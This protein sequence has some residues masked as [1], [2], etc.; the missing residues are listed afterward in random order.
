MNSLMYWVMKLNKTASAYKL[1]LASELLL[2]TKQAK[3]KQ[4]KLA[5]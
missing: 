3:L 1:T 4:L 5:Y 2:K